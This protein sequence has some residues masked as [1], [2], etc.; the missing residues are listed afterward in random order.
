[1]S[2]PAFLLVL[3]ILLIPPHSG[4]VDPSQCIGYVSGI[5]LSDGPVPVETTIILDSDGGS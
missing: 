3:V 1:M 2:K 5:C 4:V